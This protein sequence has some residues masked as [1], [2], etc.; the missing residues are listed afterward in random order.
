M[1]VAYPPGNRP[2]FDAL[3]PGHLLVSELPPGA[4]PTRIRFLARNRL[5]AALSAGDRRGRGGAAVGG[6]EHGRLGGGLLRPLMAVPGPVHSGASV[7]PHLMVR[8][9]Q[10]VLVTGRRRCWN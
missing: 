1:D 4:H 5:I 7:A 3:A 8:N 6:P 9:G 2:L 10:A